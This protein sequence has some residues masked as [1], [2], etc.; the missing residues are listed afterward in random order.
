MKVCG[1][2]C[3]VLL[4]PA[5]TLVSCSEYFSTLKMETIGCLSTN[6]TALYPSRQYSSK[7]DCFYR[8]MFA[9]DCI[10]KGSRLESRRAFCFLQMQSLPVGADVAPSVGVTRFMN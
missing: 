6:Y 5:L 3:H 9:N 1:K 4:P 7:Y 2:Q 10:Y 8:A